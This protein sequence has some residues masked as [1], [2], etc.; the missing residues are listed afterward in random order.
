MK[1][2]QVHKHNQAEIKIDTNLLATFPSCEKIW[3]IK[4]KWAEKILKR[5]KIESMVY[6]GDI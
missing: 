5:I 1:A 4:M 3:I 2:L 6:H